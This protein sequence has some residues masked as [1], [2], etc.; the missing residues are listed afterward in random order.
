MQVSSGP[1]DQSTFGMPDQRGRGVAQ[2]PNQSGGVAGEGPSVV[3]T[4]RLVAAA[5]TTQVDSHHPGT[6]K[7]AELMAP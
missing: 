3:S 5:V 2:S 6:G 1:A 7:S 4:W